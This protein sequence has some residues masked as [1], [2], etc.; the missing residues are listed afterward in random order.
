ML[1]LLSNQMGNTQN[2][3]KQKKIQKAKQT[4]VPKYPNKAFKTT[5]PTKSNTYPQLQIGQK[6]EINS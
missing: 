1:P 6:V 5:N 2:F 3:Q 4:H